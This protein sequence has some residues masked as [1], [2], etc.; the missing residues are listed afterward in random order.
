MLLT[1]VFSITHVLVPI[2]AIAFS[3][4]I[5]IL[6][7]YFYHKHKASVMEERR[8]MIEKG[9]VPPEL[10]SQLKKDADRHSPLSKGINLL[11]IALGIIS[12]YLISVNWHTDDAISIICAII[13][14][15]GIAN[16]AK[17]FLTNKIEGNNE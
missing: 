7:I 6:V 4:S 11:A 12:G 14:W 10:G 16:I 17:S 9:M 13:F 5:P 3:F 1:I 15:L 2:I 8:L